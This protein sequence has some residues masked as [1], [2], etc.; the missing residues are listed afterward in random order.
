MPRRYDK[1]VGRRENKTLVM[2]VDMQSL[3][4]SCDDKRYIKLIGM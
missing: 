4:I 3:K 2:R 1:G